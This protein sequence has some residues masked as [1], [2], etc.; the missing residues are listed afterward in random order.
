ML[1]VRGSLKRL[2][3][4][5][6]EVL[7]PWL[8]WRARQEGDRWIVTRPFLGVEGR[9]RT[10]PEALSSL[11][12]ALQLYLS[13]YPVTAPPVSRWKKVELVHFDPASA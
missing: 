2:G 9:G 4:P 11:D 3:A 10:L 7:P 12:Y 6:G 5:Y 13:R 1:D 8:E